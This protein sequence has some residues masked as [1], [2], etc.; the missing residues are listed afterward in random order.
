L[1]YEIP[2]DAYPGKVAPR[3]TI[4]DREDKRNG[5]LFSG[6]HIGSSITAYLLKIVGKDFCFC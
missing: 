4:F 3:K 1:R 5:L 6:S 2:A